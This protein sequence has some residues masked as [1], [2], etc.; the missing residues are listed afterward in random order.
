MK[1][2]DELTELLTQLDADSA[3]AIEHE[4]I[5]EEYRAKVRANLPRAYAAGAGTTALERTIHSLYVAK[6]IGRWVT[7]DLPP[8][9]PP[10]RRKRPGAAPG[11]P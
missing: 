5:A 3:K 1:G 7:G 10:T 8:E 11:R 9:K 2:V 6:T 4:R